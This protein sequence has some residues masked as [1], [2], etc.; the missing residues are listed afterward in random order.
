MAYVVANAIR[1]K[2]PLDN[3]EPERWGNVIAEGLAS[4]PDIQFDRGSYC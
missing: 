4:L 2:C 1:E 3:C